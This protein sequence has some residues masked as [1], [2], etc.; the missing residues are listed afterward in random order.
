MRKLFVILCVVCASFL[1]AQQI[2]FS[3]ILS[4]EKTP[5]IVGAREDRQATSNFSSEKSYSPLITLD[6]VF[7]ESYLNVI[8]SIGMIE[9]GYP[10]TNATP[11][12]G[13]I[14]YEFGWRFSPMVFLGAG[15]GARGYYTKKAMASAITFLSML[16]P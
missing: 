7:F 3:D 13:G 4:A 14:E 10:V 2:T 11:M 15:I 12:G 16:E 8:G 5:K 9:Y 6:Y 1:H